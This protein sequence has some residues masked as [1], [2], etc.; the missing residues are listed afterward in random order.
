MLCF[1]SSLPS[2]KEKMWIL[3]FCDVFMF[4]F[5]YELLPKKLHTF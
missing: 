5:S 3:H 1:Y 4:H 2:Q